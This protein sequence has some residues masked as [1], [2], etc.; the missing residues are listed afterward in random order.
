MK[1]LSIFVVVLSLVLASSAFAGGKYGGKKGAP[2]LDEKFYMMSGMIVKNAS[3]LGMSEEQKDAVMEKKYALKKDLV[4]RN[5]EIELVCIDLSR[6]LWKESVDADV[7]NALV[8]KKYQLKADKT[9]A[10]VNAYAGL[11]NSLT[12]EQKETMKSL[13]EMKGSM[14]SMP[15]CKGVLDKT[16]KKK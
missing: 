15:C 5:A 4:R 9:K 13:C 7:V 2:D 14:C 11:K 8:D 1:K 16:G 6:E 3:E 10:V 12:E